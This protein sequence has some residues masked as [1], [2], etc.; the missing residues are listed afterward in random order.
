MRNLLILVVGGLLVYSAKTKSDTL[1]DPVLEIVGMKEPRNLRNK[2]PGNIRHGAKWDGLAS[3]QPDSAFA[4]FVDF[5]YGYRALAILLRNYQRRY[6]INSV[7]G[8]LER[9]APSIEN[10]TGSYINSVAASMGV[11]SDAPLNLELRHV[12][13]DLAKAITKHEGGS[14]PADHVAYLNRGL[15]L[16]GVA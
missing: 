3:E 8:V 7:R 9:Y 16:V 15:D 10:D 13:Y 11:S 1:I 6:G 12:L 14:F 5:P 4:T 2:N